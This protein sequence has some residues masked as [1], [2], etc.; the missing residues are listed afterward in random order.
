MK[1]REEAHG[2]QL[3]FLKPFISNRARDDA[4]AAAG[5]EDDKGGRMALL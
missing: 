2:I 3:C 5:Y 4:A 1:V